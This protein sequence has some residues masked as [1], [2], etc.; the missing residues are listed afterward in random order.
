MK[1]K[2]DHNEY[3]EYLAR[4]RTL[5]SKKRT[6]FSIERTL[7]AYIR[8]AF[9]VFLF[10]III[11]RIFEFNKFSIFLGIISIIFGI[12]ILMIGIIFSFNRR[13]KIKKAKK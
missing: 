7:L 4:E 13:E 3:E 5:F 1:K 8:T 2:L 10:G 12:A 9:T 6:L 11:I